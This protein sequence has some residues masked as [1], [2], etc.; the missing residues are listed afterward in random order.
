M[1]EATQKPTFIGGRMRVAREFLGF[2][3]QGLADELGVSKRGI[4][5]NETRNR[6]PGG[7]V[8]NGFV[9]LGINANW[10]LTGEGPM[11]LNPAAELGRL[12]AEARG[13]T[14][15]QQLAENINIQAIN[16][17]DMESGRKIA[18]AETIQDYT[19]LCGADPGLLFALRDRALVAVGM[20]T[21]PTKPTE[22]AAP[23]NTTALAA[24]IDGLA[25]AGCPPAKLGQ[26]GV[27]YYQDAIEQG[28][29]TPTGVGDGDGQSAA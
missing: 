17:L 4:Q 11:L 22:P 13:D 20:L 6:V 28:L 27:R 16:L 14:P 25:K 23:I 3:Q 2:S 29:I 8:I 26:M 12:M 18:D 7:D 10:L 21:A 9:Y 5:D 24:I 19:T 15:I 1:K